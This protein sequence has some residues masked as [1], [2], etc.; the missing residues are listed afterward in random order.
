MVSPGT[1]P[2]DIVCMKG[3]PVKAAFIVETG[4][5]EVRD[6][7]PPTLEHD[8]D[9]IVQMTRAA[10]CGSDVYTLYQA[11]LTQADLSKPGHPGHEGV[12]V[13]VESRSLRYPV[14]ARVL[15]ITGM[16]SRGG[17]FAELQLLTENDLVLL[18]EEGDD[19]S[20]LMAQ[21]YG[22]TLFSMR[23]FWERERSPRAMGETGRS[24]AITGAGST[25]LFFLQHAFHWG[26]EK[27]IVS[28]LNPARLAIAE[29]LGAR[30]VL[31]S[32]ADFVGVVQEETGGM[33]ADLVIESS[34][35]DFCRAQAVEALATGGTI[36][37]F[38]VPERVTSVPFPM[39]AAFRKVAKIQFSNGAQLEPG[40]PDFHEA[41]E[42]IKNGQAVVDYCLD[43]E[44]SLERIGEA[45]EV[46]RDGQNAPVKLQIKVA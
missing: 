33:G 18:P 12:G 14:G 43:S 42:Q 3:N 16:R 1:W 39:G 35:S 21:Q 38:G 27:V 34:G 19:A 37:C 28:D 25:G 29:K 41:V 2:S 24:A 5:I 4:L 45:M 46:A 8:G 10:I 9:V 7:A 17:C 22:T 23:K 31:A 20:Y 44:Y 6:T 15:T 36:G 40:L 30:T 11:E 26:F 32:E 13:V